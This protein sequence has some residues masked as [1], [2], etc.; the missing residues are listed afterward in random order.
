MR[1]LPFLLWCATLAGSACML[2]A[3]KHKALEADR[4]LHAVRQSMRMESESIR[5]L[6]A[7]W[8]YLTRPERI[9]DLASRYLKSAP[10]ASGRVIQVN[11]LPM[12]DPVEAQPLTQEP[13][14]T[15]SPEVPMLP[16]PGIIPIS[17]EGSSWR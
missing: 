6:E 9:Q 11:G 4:D 12:P 8:Q 1:R 15:L 2:Y 17:Q 14:A 13:P 3:V 5:V 7:E 10:P 16:K